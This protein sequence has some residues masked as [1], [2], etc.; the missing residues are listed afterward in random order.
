MTKIVKVYCLFEQSGTFKNA[1]KRAGID[2]AD[3]DIQNMFGETDHVVDIFDQINTAYHTINETIFDEITP[4]DLIIA[5]F[6]CIYFS[7][8]NQMF[9]CGTSLFWKNKN[10]ESVLRGIIDR[11]AERQKYYDLLLKLC[12]I[13]ETRNLRL[14]V[15]NP[16]SVNHYLYNN[17][18]YKPAVVDVDRTNKGDY[19][20][21]PTQ[22]FFV[23][24]TPTR[25]KTVDKRRDA[26]KIA[27]LSGNHGGGICNTERSLISS[28]YAENFINDYILGIRTEK[29]ERTLFDNL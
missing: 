25:L 28:E 27:Y 6:P 20:T 29:T 5:F 11:A 17:F 22:Y 7:Q 15:E 9:F 12:C 13:V 14:I 2:A 21:K 24:C 10:R 4:D 8:Y 1:F 16:F 18:P 26:I 3:Y 19:F 23:N